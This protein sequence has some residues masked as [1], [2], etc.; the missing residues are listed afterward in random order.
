M[1]STRPN[2]QSYDSIHMNSTCRNPQTVAFFLRFMQIVSNS[3]RIFIPGTWYIYWPPHHQPG[4]WGVIEARFALSISL[5]VQASR[6]VF[7]KFDKS[8][9]PKP[10]FVF[11]RTYFRNDYQPALAAAAHLV[12]GE[13]YCCCCCCC[14]LYFCSCERSPYFFQYEISIFRNTDCSS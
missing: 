7:D 9:L 10:F 11:S 5:E 8:A 6:F 14:C 4:G 1:R 13:A 2:L 12:I 3:L